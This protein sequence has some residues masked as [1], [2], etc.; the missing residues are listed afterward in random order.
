[1]NGVT[2]RSL[3]DFLRPPP[4]RRCASDVNFLFEQDRPAAQA[5]RTHFFRRRGRVDCRHAHAF[6]GL[7]RIVSERGELRWLPAEWA[8]QG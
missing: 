1:L 4:A 8:L 6:P 3:R 7:G 2:D 5:M